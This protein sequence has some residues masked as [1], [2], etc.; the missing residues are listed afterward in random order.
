[1]AYGNNRV[2]KQPRSHFQQAGGSSI[3]FRHPYLAGQ[4]GDGITDSV[5]I[6]SCLKLEGQY[7]DATQ[8]QDNAKQ[9]VLID[10]T[11]VTITN[12]LLNG[13]I[14]MPV[15]RTTG[16]VSSGDFVA[17]CHLIRSIGDSI[18]GLVIKTDYIDGKAITRVYYGVAVQSCPDDRSMGND[19]AEY[20]VKLTYAGWIEAYGGTDSTMNKKAV[21]ATGNAK[22]LE[23][24]FS[25]YS[26]QGGS[27]GNGALGTGAFPEATADTVEGNTGGSLGGDKVSKNSVNSAAKLG[28]SS[29]NI[30]NA[31]SILTS[32]AN[33]L[34]TAATA[35]DDDDD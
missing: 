23:A 32:A 29:N 18:G 8:S 30:V 1:M 25:P 5:D 20:P 2:G 12:R 26:V 28:G 16:L 15:I 4:L 35:D 9:T 19:V 33:T 3:F 17:I 27:T 13:V 10:G 24:Y 34:T 11:V 6:S 31:Q 22:G 7:F 21:W 14:T